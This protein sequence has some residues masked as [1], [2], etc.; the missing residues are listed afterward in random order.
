MKTNNIK[1]FISINIVI[2]LLI[3][4]SFDFLWFEIEKHKYI[5]NSEN[6]AGFFDKQV[7][8]HY[9]KDVP[10]IM[11][12]ID[13]ERQVKHN[14]KQPNNSILLLGCSYTYGSNLQPTQ[15]FSYYLSKETGRT[16]YNWGVPGG[17]DSTSVIF[18]A[19]ERYKR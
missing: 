16:V 7:I 1:K 3:L 2:I 6:S 13:E 19:E 18:F 14:D 9:A 4:I 11:P 12:F 15:N 17:G 10:V 5:K 8:T